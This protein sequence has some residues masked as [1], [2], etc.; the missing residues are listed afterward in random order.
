MTRLEL[1]APLTALERSLHRSYGF[2]PAVVVPLLARRLGAAR[3]L[4]TGK[5]AAVAVGTAVLTAPAVIAC[6]DPL[7]GLA[8]L[9]STPTTLT[10]TAL[11]AHQTDPFALSGTGAGTDRASGPA[12]GLLAAPAPAPTPRLGLARQRPATPSKVGAKVGATVAA[13]AKAKASRPTATADG[14][15]SRPAATAPPRKPA[16]QSRPPH[17]RQPAHHHHRLH[18]RPWWWVYLPAPRLTHRLRSAA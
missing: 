14:P 4:L 9:A 13:K 11:T 8:P 5:V 12:V 2:L 1:A 15:R 18:H 16:H 7:S 3:T 17:Q 6:S 10:T